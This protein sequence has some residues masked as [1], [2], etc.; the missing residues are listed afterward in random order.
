MPDFSTFKGYKIRDV[1]TFDRFRIDNDIA[2]CQCTDSDA[3][4]VTNCSEKVGVVPSSGLTLSSVSG[5]VGIV[6]PLPNKRKRGLLS[7]GEIGY[8]LHL[9]IKQNCM[10]CKYSY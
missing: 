10:L 9:D 5:M 3:I 2:L 6:A 7:L 1:D 8:I 4:G